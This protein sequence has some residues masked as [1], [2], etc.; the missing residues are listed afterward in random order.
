MIVIIYF[1]LKEASGTKIINYQVKGKNGVETA[2]KKPIF[3]AY[4]ATARK[5]KVP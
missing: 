4:V 1:H 5:Q 2:N 3:L